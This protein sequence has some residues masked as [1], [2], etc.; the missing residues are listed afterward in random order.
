MTAGSSGDGRGSERPAHG[1]QS[2]AGCVA[3]P[4]RKWG[5]DDPCP[6]GELAFTA[7][8]QFGTTSSTFAC[9]IRTSTTDAVDVCERVRAAIAVL[10]AADAALYRSKESG[11]NRVTVAGGD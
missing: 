1:W 4:A 9:S 11:R 8:D 10:A 5:A 7:V 3:S 6:S 2:R